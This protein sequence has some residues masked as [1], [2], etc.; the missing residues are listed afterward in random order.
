MP[1]AG[2]FTPRPRRWIHLLR[3]A[4]AVGALFGSACHV[5]APLDQPVP[6]LGSAVRVSITPDA[7]QRVARET[8]R[9][10]LQQVDGQF[11]GSQGDSVRISVLIDRDPRYA[12]QTLRQVFSF[13]Q[14]DVVQ[15][16]SHVFSRRRTTLLGVGAVGLLALLI[17]QY[18]S[19]GGDPGP[20]DGGPDPGSPAIRI[21]I[22]IFR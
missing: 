21:G 11:V 13:S 12:Q 7:A 1:Q 3:S 8:G 19:S 6:T 17:S 5:Y 22:P 14:S 16:Q 10:A 9:P 18:A 20:T 15:Y 4:A 2:G